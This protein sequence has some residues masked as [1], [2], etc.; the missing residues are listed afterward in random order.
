MSTYMIFATAFRANVTEAENAK[1][2]DLMRAAMEVNSISMQVATVEG[3]FRED[4]QDEYTVE[5]T[6]QACNIGWWDVLLAADIAC[7]SF[8][9]DC[10][11]AVDMQ[12]F[13][14]ELVA[15]LEGGSYQVTSIGHWRQAT[16]ADALASGAYTK[17]RGI[18][19]V[20]GES[21]FICE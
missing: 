11:L 15:P 3:C 16:K 19:G 12:S 17:F 10:I 4:G 9:Q 20:S 21:Y 2:N 14:A 5:D 13:E 1:R 8:K 18:A 6:M 7:K